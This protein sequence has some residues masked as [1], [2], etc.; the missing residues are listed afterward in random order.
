MLSL[1]LVL[2]LL[3]IIF[4]S[5]LGGAAL[6][7]IP[8]DRLRQI[9]EEVGKNSSRVDYWVTHSQQ[10]TWALR[11]TSRISCVAL[12]LV[13]ARVIAGDSFPIF[14]VVI[15][16]VVTGLLVAFPG[17]LIPLAWGQRGGERIGMRLIPVFRV[18]AVILAPIS[19]VCR[20]VLNG[21]LVLASK[22]PISFKPLSLKGELDQLIGDRKAAKRLDEEEKAMIRHIFKFGDMMA[23]EVMTPRISMSCLAEDDT[24]SR[25][26][27]LIKEEHHSRIPVY[28]GNSDNVVGVLYAKD[29]LSHRREE[30]MEDINVGSLMREPIFVPETKKLDD[31]F[32]ELRSKRTHMAI[33]VDEYGCTTGLVT[34]EDI[35]EEIV[36]EIQDEYDIDEKG[37]YEKLGEGLYRVDAR[38]PANDAREELGLNIPESEEYD[39]LAGFVCSLCGRVPAAGETVEWNGY[40]IRVL[41]ASSRNVIKLEIRKAAGGGISNFKF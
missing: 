21:A 14:K 28:S 33:V 22:S 19:S 26:R 7:S 27:Q 6:R 3:G 8:I 25:A 24:V 37:L 10:I 18:F 40:I 38:L 20:G 11:V 2:I 36:G 31:L 5:T 17:S 1:L 39:T 32:S 13:L 41:E 23:K 12:A 34:M 4:F 16:L 9:R 15:A 35:L 29:L 30:G